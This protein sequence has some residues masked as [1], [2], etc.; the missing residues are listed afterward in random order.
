MKKAQEMRNVEENKK[1]SRH[2]IVAITEEF[3]K[4][5]IS[6]R[7]LL[8]YMMDVYTPFLNILAPK[9]EE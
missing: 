6:S 9:E 2:N 7:K 5:G 4:E 1:S 8:Q 3:E